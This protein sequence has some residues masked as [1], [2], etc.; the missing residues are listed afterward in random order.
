[1]ALIPFRFFSTRP[2]FQI[3]PM[4][5][6]AY[7]LSVAAIVGSILMALGVGLNLGID[8]RGGSMIEARFQQPP[9]IN[10]LRDKVAGLN[11][12]EVTIQE[13]GEPRDILI[14][15]QKQEGGAEDQTAAIEAV[16]ATL[17]DGVEIRR[18]EFIG[19]TVGEEL[20]EAGA[21]AVLLSMLGIVAY[22]W[23]RFEWQFAVAGV[24][25]LVHDVA[26]TI[27]LFA[28]TGWEFNL[29][30]VAALLTIAGY[31]INDTVVVF[32]RVRENLRK[33]KQETLLTLLNRSIN[34][35][36][37]RTV[38]TSVTTLLALL[39]LAIFGGEIIRSFTYAL[40]WGIAIGTYSS[41]FVAAC[42]LLQMRDVRNISRTPTP[43]SDEAEALPGSST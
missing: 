3:V 20:K 24:L 29:S 10:E 17:G 16:K 31:S 33:Y 9:S 37:S 11:L 25:A 12:G 1:M 14:R 2:N 26:I 18:T 40:I 41:I 43:G 36:L 22:I 6:A 8:F 23:F 7:A 42:L 30:T 28:V 4:R 13:F 39:A 15:V 19:P 35:T 27:G 38:M 21:I 34:D 5:K 32:D